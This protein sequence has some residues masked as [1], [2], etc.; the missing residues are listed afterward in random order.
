[1]QMESELQHLKAQISPHFLFNTMNNFYGLAVERSDK[2]PG[3]MVRLSHLL[4][5]SLYETQA[6]SVPLSREID[7][8]QD[9]IALEKIRLEDN[10][11]F[12]FDLQ[13]AEN[14]AVKI[15]PLILIVFVENAFKHAKNV[16]D[17]C[18]RIKINLSVSDEGTLRFEVTNN[19]LR[20]EP[21]PFLEMQG[22]G[23]ENV[24]KR[25]DV[26]YPGDLHQLTT[27]KK[28]DTFRINLIVHLQT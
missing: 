11:D 13:I 28:G 24:R 26:L 27:E 5:Y 8:L 22:I 6:P 20:G 17:D 12:Q 14:C 1:M 2:L 18:I 25:L 16:Q 10:L 15:A 21:H 23:L 7:Q 19:C 4:R 3:L 9:Y